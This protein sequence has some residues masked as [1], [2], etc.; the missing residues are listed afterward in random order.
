MRF[1]QLL[2]INFVLVLR[3]Q[4]AV[5]EASGVVLRLLLAILLYSVRLRHKV[6]N[7]QSIHYVAGEEGANEENDFLE[8]PQ[9]A[10]VVQ[11]VILFSLVKER[12]VGSSQVN[13]DEFSFAEWLTWSLPSQDSLR[14][15]D[16]EKGELLL[17]DLK[18]IIDVVLQ[19]NRALSE[20]D[21]FT[22]LHVGVEI[23]VNAAVNH[24]FEISSCG[25]GEQVRV[26]FKIGVSE[27]HIV[28][29]LF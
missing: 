20:H 18:Q 10:Q 23:V 9:I 16:F 5:I 2:N 11:N 7:E 29:L 14:L 24:I 4:V 6:C 27:R 8:T 25:L 17:A 12:A 13:A 1:I 26:G 28:E 15:G 22:D 3:C 19:L 21:V